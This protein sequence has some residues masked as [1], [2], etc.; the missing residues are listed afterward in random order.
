MAESPETWLIEAVKVNNGY[1]EPRL[2]ARFHE[3]FPELKDDWNLQ[4]LR[5]FLTSVDHRNDSTLYDDIRVSDSGRKSEFH[6]PDD[7]DDR[8]NLIIRP[9]KESKKA[10]TTKS[11]KKSRTIPREGSIGS[12]IPGELD[13]PKH[14]I[15]WK[16]LSEN[17]DASLKCPKGN[18]YYS[19]QGTVTKRYW[20][21]LATQLS[22]DLPKTVKKQEI[23]RHIFDQCKVTPPFEESI[24]LGGQQGGG[25]QKTTFVDLCDFFNI[26]CQP[27]LSRRLRSTKMT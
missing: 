15:A 9:K 24:H 20:L 17:G 18:D 5:R 11:E 2:L 23:P 6:D 27:I 1:G 8:S 10:K 25:V 26:E 13:H 22:V 12:D 16:L 21:S 19:P 3:K 14:K 4:L 7:Y